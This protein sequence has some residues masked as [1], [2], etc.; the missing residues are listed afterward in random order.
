MKRVVIVGAG[1][2]GLS[3]ALHCAR[4]G[5][6]VTLIDRGPPERDGCSYGNAGM[7]TP[8]HFVPLA[9][10]GMVALG[11]KWMWNPASPFYVRPRVSLD[12][13]RWGLLFWRAS[14][15]AR[16]ARAAPLLRDM[17][18]AGRRE[19][20]ALAAEPGFDF[21]L[22]RDDLL[23][24]CKSAHALDE[25]AGVAERAR[26]PGLEARVMDAAEIAAL[27]PRIRMD[28]AGGVLYPQDCSFM[29]ARFMQGLQRAVQAAGVAFAWNTEAISWRIE[30]TCRI[31]A[32]P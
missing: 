5:F 30:A 1:V 12:L 8:S 11:L 17:A 9:A 23:L 26:V 6:R 16:V 4:R 28:V 18:L 13:L 3:T 25:E 19:Y 32:A 29:P 15:K 7:I 21:G 31:R 14:T 2:V 10:P 22:A 20:E 24:L 27:E